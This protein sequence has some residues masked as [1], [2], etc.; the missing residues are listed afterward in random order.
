MPSSGRVDVVPCAPAGGGGGCHAAGRLKYPEHSSPHTAG[1]TAQAPQ[2]TKT[3]A[4]QT[5]PAPTLS[6]NGLGWAPHPHTARL[7]A[8]P[9][10]SHGSAA[11]G[12]FVCMI[13]YDDLCMYA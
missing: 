6:E 3:G 11:Q 2:T 4:L 8:C 10:V 13:L 5:S 1:D 12:C 9:M 7:T